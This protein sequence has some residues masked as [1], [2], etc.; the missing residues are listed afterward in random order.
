MILSKIFESLELVKWTSFRNNEDSRYLTLVLPWVLMRLPYGANTVPVEGLSFEEEVTGSDSSHFCWGNAAYVLGQRI[1]NAF[2]LY[3]WT[4]A[5][6]GV[7]AAY[8]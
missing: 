4:A 7:K 5:I 8:S 3:G 1:T 6:R 2:A